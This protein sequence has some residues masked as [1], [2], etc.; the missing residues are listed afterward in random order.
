MYRLGKEMELTRNIRLRILQWV[1]RVMRMKDGRVPKSTESIKRR[2]KTSWK[3]Q[4][5]M[6]RCSGQKY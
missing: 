6:V 1:S 2:K 3:A 4:R 5:Q